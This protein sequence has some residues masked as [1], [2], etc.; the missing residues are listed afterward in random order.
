MPKLGPCRACK[1]QVSSEARSCPHCG[2]PLPFLDGL[3]E[4]EGL[5]RA[6]DKMGAIKKVRKLAGLDLK[7]AK[8][9]VDSWDK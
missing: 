9:L 1:A 2:Q 5:F 3:E 6:G 4:A 7:G 8:D